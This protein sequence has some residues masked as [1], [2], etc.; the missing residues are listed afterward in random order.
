MLGNP[1]HLLPNRRSLP[2]HVAC[3][4]IRYPIPLP[5]ALPPSVQV[6]IM[7]FAVSLLRS[8]VTV[9]RK[10]TPFCDGRMARWTIL[11]IATKRYIHQSTIV[12][13][14]RPRSLPSFAASLRAPFGAVVLSGTLAMRGWFADLKSKTT[15]MESLLTLAS[16]SWT[17][18]IAQMRLGPKMG[19]KSSIRLYGEM[20]ISS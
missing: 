14:A 16:I 2:F 17:S 10:D 12:E 4:N 15:V 13:L 5:T 8:R 20:L 19:A 3:I 7:P 1:M 9:G 6:S 11:M 18:T